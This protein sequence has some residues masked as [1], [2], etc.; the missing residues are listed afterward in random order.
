[1]TGRHA[2]TEGGNVL[3]S[4]V[5]R[6]ITEWINECRSWTGVLLDASKILE[7]ANE[8][9]K[10]LERENAHLR[11]SLGQLRSEVSAIDADRTELRKV[12][13]E[14]TRQITQVVYLMRRHIEE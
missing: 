5:S 3:G 14:L 4:E 12:L 11:D 6:T 9:V 7:A 13:Q 2:G 8:K 1:M 10:S